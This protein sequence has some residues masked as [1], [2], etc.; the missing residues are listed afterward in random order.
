MRSAVPQ[1]DYAIFAKCDSCITDPFRGIVL[2]ANCK[3]YLAVDQT[4][5]DA[6]KQL[7]DS[8]LATQSGGENGAPI[9]QR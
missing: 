9:F 4:A 5:G 2:L 6:S 3:N 7:V 1:Y 8:G